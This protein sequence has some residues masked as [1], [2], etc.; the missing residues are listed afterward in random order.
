M[1]LNVKLTLHSTGLDHQMPLLGGTSDCL[2]HSSEC[3][4][5]FGSTGLGHQMPLPWGMS[6][7]SK[8]QADLMHDCK[9]QDDLR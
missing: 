2:L 3:Q 9:C 8:C 7:S 4:D 1:T 5:D 6:A